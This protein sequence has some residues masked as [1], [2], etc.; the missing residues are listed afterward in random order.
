MFPYLLVSQTTDW[1]KSFGGTASD[2]VILHLQI[3]M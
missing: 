2:M 1:V 3:R